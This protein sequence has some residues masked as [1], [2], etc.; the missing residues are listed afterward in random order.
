MPFTAF[1]GSLTYGYEV[2]QH[3]I[4]DDD[5]KKGLENLIKDFYFNMQHLNNQKFGLSK[6]DMRDNT[7]AYAKYQ[8]VVLT[9]IPDTLHDPLYVTCN[10]DEPLLKVW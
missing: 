5:C 6:L 1:T 7:T 3:H 4:V 2:K 8:N 10:V 9:R